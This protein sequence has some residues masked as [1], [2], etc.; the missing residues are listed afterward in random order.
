MSLSLA[1]Q[2]GDVSFEQHQSVIVTQSDQGFASDHW[3]TLALPLL[4]MPM[5]VSRMLC[6]HGVFWQLLLPGFGDSDSKMMQQDTN[7]LCRR[8]LSM[9]SVVATP[10]LLRT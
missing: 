5:C 8:R 4:A 1:P 10:W 3:Q 7:A 6:K 9:L 2:T